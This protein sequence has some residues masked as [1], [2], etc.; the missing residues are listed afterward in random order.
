MLNILGED[1]TPRLNASWPLYGLC[2]VMILLNG[3]RDQIWERRLGVV[4]ARDD[5]RKK[6]LSC[7]LERSRN[8][9]MHINESVRNQ[10]F[11]FQ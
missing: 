10:T 8:L 11:D 5:S 6:I 4:G 9:L 1:L 2:W 7:Q 3:F